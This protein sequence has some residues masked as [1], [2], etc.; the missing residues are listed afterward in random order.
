MKNIKKYTSILQ[1]CPLFEDIKPADID[2]LLDC[3]SAIPRKH[4]KNDFIFSLGD[5]VQSIGIILS[6]GV[7]VLQEDYW[8]TR[9]ILAHIEAGN[10]F[11]ES[12]SCAQTKQLPV[13][14]IA[15]Q[16]TEILLIDYRHIINACPT[17][18]DFHIQLIKNMM[19]ILA[20]KNIIL[21]QKL[22]II[23]HRTTRERLLSYLSSQAIR[24]EKNRFTIPF[25][26][27]E[28]ADFLSVERSAMSAELSRMQEDG[29]IKTRR[30]EFELLT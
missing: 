27:Q 11:G 10:L 18:H 25:N 24:A 15:S 28:L 30:S 22:E 9:T 2:I 12:F 19:T 21:T 14:V 17:F 20:Q 8:G 26:R 5:S 13:S 4:Q 3:L 16:A 1:K 29:L 7:Y 23:S 6:G